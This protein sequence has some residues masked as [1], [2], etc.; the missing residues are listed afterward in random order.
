MSSLA[1]LPRRIPH[2]VPGSQHFG[3]LFR[4]ARS[5]DPADVATDMAELACAVRAVQDLDTYVPLGM[6]RTFDVVITAAV[7]AGH[8]VVDMLDQ[9]QPDGCGPVLAD[10]GPW[11]WWLVPPGTAETW[12]EEHSICVTAPFRVRV[13]PRHR[14]Q[15]AVPSAEPHR[16]WLRPPSGTHLVGPQMLRRA[17]SLHRPRPSPLTAADSLVNSGVL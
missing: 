10:G 17:L 3:P 11:L 14:R 4:P 6:A 15:P 8:L 12:Q 1:P 5:P 2:A 7:D 13:P 16:Y 9:E